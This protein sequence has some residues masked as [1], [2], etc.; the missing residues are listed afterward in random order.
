MIYVVAGIGRCGTTMLMR[1]LH[2]GGMTPATDNQV[3]YET[4]NMTVAQ[5]DIASF[6]GK[7][8]KWLE[9]SRFKLPEGY[10]YKV[11]W[12]SRDFKEQGKSIAKWI[13]PM[14]PVKRQEIRKIAKSL[15]ADYAACFRI[16]EQRKIPVLRLDFEKVLLAPYTTAVSVKE[17][18]GIDLD[19]DKMKKEVINRHPGC[20]HDLDIERNFY[21]KYGKD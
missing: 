9:P 14:V 3:G 19:L 1:M 21:R 6:D 11:I 4:E 7:L 13:S 18:F 15:P 12:M 17:F 20:M 5:R 16:F 2:A 8:V 10:D